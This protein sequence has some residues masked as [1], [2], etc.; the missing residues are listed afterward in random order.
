MKLKKIPKII[1]NVE[2]FF[3]GSMLIG[4]EV[5]QELASHG[6][7]EYN[8]S[9][10]HLS[11]IGASGMYTALYLMEADKRKNKLTIALG[12]PTLFSVVEV[13]SPLMTKHFPHPFRY[14]YQDIICYW[15]ASFVAL[16]IKELSEKLFDKKSSL[17]SMAK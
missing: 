16:G 7:T 15:G 11:D 1:Q 10:G 2:T 14:D 17:E 8:W 3:W 9:V 4:G 12:I 13:M 5:M 6:G